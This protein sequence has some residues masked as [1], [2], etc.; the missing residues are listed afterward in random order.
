MNIQES[1]TSSFYRRYIY[2][3]QE[4]LELRML[5]F[6]MPE[7]MFMNI[8]IGIYDE[9][10]VYT[11]RGIYQRIKKNSKYEMVKT[12]SAYPRLTEKLYEEK[13]RKELGLI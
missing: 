6:R 8:M 13:C 1:D 3:P 2:D 4:K 5:G 7:S 9:D 10:I 12:A 11:Y